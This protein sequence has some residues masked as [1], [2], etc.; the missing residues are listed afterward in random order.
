M[1][2]VDTGLAKQQCLFL[3]FWKFLSSS[4]QNK[5]RNSPG[6]TVCISWMIPIL[7]WY[8]SINPLFSKWRNSKNSQKRIVHVTFKLYAPLSLFMI[9]GPVLFSHIDFIWIL[10]TLG[11]MN[12]EIIC[13]LS[14]LAIPISLD[15]GHWWS[16]GMR[17]VFSFILPSKDLSF[18]FLSTVFISDLPPKRSVSSLSFYI[19]VSCG[20]ASSNLM[21]KFWVVL[22]NFI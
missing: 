13:I 5:K 4:K 6:F 11:L 17:N 15:E 20:K 9:W 3:L 8:Q 22:N 19:H 2:L 18:L 1:R 21:N 12:Y 10:L 14:S 16:W 7:S